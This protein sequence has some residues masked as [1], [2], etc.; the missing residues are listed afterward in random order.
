M[1]PVLD[2]VLPEGVSVTRRC[3]GT[4]EYLFLMNFSESVKT[5]RLPDSFKAAV[6]V[7]GGG[8]VSGEITLPVYGVRV[9]LS[10]LP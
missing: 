2:T 1:K 3:G 8:S 7:I 10:D 9:L 4:E 5:F 6:D